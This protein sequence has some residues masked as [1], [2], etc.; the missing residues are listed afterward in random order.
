MSRRKTLTK[1]AEGLANSA[2]AEGFGYTADRKRANPYHLWPDR[3]KI[4]G[5]IKRLPPEDREAVKEL[6]PKHFNQRLF[7]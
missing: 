2:I 6:K 4:G 7:R 1:L 5:M 3:D